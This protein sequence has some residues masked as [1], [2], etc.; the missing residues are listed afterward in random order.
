MHAGTPRSTIEDEADD[1]FTALLGHER[2]PEWCTR[3]VA[4]QIARIRD[5]WV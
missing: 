2:T 1:F 3:E 5:Q 4:E